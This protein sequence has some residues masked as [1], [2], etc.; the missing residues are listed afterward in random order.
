MFSKIKQLKNIIKRAVP[1]IQNYSK[2][3]FCVVQGHHQDQLDI[4][5]LNNDFL[6]MKPALKLKNVQLACAVAGLQAV[7]KINDFCILAF[8]GWKADGAVVLGVLK[9]KTEFKA[10]PGQL[11]I[12]DGK[13]NN[14]LAE[15][16]VELFGD[17]LSCMAG[18]A[19]GLQQATNGGG[20]LQVP[21]NIKANNKNINSLGL[22]ATH[23]QSLKQNL[24]Q[25]KNEH[26]KQH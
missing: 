25:L 11:V 19:N 20:I 21:L 13:H 14:V 22:L 3:Y 6:P 17:V 10:V 4:E 9:Q 15:P 1:G 26:I 18:L 2:L 8:T 16:L 5:I 24:N 7:P 23:L 12:G